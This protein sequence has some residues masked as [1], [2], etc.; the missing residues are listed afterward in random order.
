MHSYYILHTDILCVLYIC[1]CIYTYIPYLNLSLLINKM[2][3]VMLKSK[4]GSEE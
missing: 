1:I 3:I 2:K 4:I